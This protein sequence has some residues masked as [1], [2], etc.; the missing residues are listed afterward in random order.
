VSNPGCRWRPWATSFGGIQLIIFVVSICYACGDASV[1]LTT[2]RTPEQ[3]QESRSSRHPNSAGSRVP[4]AGDINGHGYQDS[5]IALHKAESPGRGEVGPLYGTRATE[6]VHTAELRSPPESHNQILVEDPSRAVHL[7]AHAAV[8][9]KT[10]ALDPPT[11]QPSGQPSV[12]P[13][14]QP[15]AQPSR[16]PSRQPTTQPSCQP[17][18]QPTAQP[19]R[20]PSRQPSGQP[21]RQPS[22]QPTVQ[23]SRQPS[24]QPTVNPTASPTVEPWSLFAVLGGTQCAESLWYGPQAVTLSGSYDGTRSSYLSTSTKRKTVPHFQWMQIVTSDGTTELVRL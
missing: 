14:R 5:I 12:R 3:S 13:S 9:K 17:S 2:W 20:Q 7:A 16:Q 23:P 21:S 1:G 24:G 4:G 22:Q 11:S 8:H 10:F 6:S 15:T 19:S 18:R